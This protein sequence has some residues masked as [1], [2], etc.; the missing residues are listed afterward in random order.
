MA[1]KKRPRATKSLLLAMK[2]KSEQLLRTAEGRRGRGLGL[3]LGPVVLSV[4]LILVQLCLCSCVDGA[5]KGP[6][7]LV[8]FPE[9]KTQ[10]QNNTNLLPGNLPGHTRT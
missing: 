7:G 10:K 3:P 9:G 1:R 8:P 6:Q 4:I 2:M 5:R